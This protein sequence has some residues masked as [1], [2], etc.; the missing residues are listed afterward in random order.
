MLQ[1]QGS[2]A[3]QNWWRK[4]LGVWTGLRDLCVHGLL[5]VIT[6]NA[7]APEIVTVQEAVTQ[8]APADSSTEDASNKQQWP[9]MDAPTWWFLEAPR[10]LGCQPNPAGLLGNTL[11]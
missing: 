8:Y 11:D 4:S 9:K 5:L 2:F 3:Q 6:L 7:G 10:A 1:L